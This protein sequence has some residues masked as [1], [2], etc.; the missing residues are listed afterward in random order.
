MHAP[1]ITD[2][3]RLH[4]YLFAALQLEHATLPPYLTALYSIH[5]STNL[6]AY[7][8]IRVV[9]VE[10]MLHLTLAAN[11]ANAV[12]YAPD[13]TRPDF[14]P[15]YPAYLPDGEDDFEVHLQPFS[16]EAIRTFM[17][18]ERPDSAPDEHARVQAHEREGHHLAGMPGDPG[19]RFF[20]IGEFYEEIRRGLEHLASELGEDALFAGDPGRQVGPE[21]YYS[22]GAEVVRVTDL[23][24]ATEAIRIIAEQGEGLGGGIF[25]FEAELA[26]YFR[27]KQIAEG[28]YYQ[29]GDSADAPTG[30]PL[31]VDW[32]A[33][34]PVKPNARVG[35]Y[36][37][38]S[39]LRA[40]AE[41]FNRDYADFLA[42]LTRAFSGQPELLIEAVAAM[43]RL[44]EAMTALIRNPI[45]GEDGVNGAP[46]FE[47]V[48]AARAAGS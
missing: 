17:S 40:A 26:H 41:A 37:E 27:F 20:S 6:D 39:E 3:D 29:E 23:A 33:V 19:M 15:S 25:D 12:G 45:P 2:T 13:L 30:P 22:G 38:G 43:F 11:I 14:V 7:D 35:D 18:I 44:K 8:V 34:Y 4:A 48:P 24:S 10:E 36:P 46:T 32:D 16:P 5:P 31:E 21:Y 28:R 9:A 42:L 47:V 1:R